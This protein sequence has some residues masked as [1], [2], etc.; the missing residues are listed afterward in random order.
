MLNGTGRDDKAFMQRCD[1]FEWS[2]WNSRISWH[3]GSWYCF[4]A[5]MKNLPLPVANSFLLSRSSYPTGLVLQHHQVAANSS[6]R[7]GP[8]SDHYEK[9]GQ[10]ENQRSLAADLNDSVAC[11]PSLM[12]RHLGDIRVTSPCLSNEERV[13]FPDKCQDCQS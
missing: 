11:D 2:V 5:A 7:L 10:P 13:Y 1:I 9:F 12:L 3:Y 4:T 6:A 8:P